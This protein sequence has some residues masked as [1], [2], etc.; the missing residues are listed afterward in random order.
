MAKMKLTGVG[1]TIK[2]LDRL[3]QRVY[4]KTVS[5]S[6]RKGAVIVARQARAN[7]RKIADPGRDEGKHLHQTISRR[8]KRY[9]AGQT[10]YIAVGPKWPGGAHGYLVE[11]GHRMVVG[12]TVER[13][14]GKQ[15]GKT[16]KA[17]N[18]DRTG[19][20]RVVGQVPPHPWYRPAFDAVGG[21]ALRAVQRDML[22][23]VMK[24]VKAVRYRRR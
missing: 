10:V 16:P 7:A 11:Y 18:E 1:E 8:T 4:K 14:S 9:N 12:G 3:Q 17:R 24:D 6:L 5:A 19:K 21:S 23:G 2:A 22:M 20:G 13:I 15:A